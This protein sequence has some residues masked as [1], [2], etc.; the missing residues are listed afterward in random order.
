VTGLNLEEM[1]VDGVL[2][3]DVSGLGALVEGGF[4]EARMIVLAAEWHALAVC[5]HCDLGS[6][7]AVETWAVLMVVGVRVEETG[8][9]QGPG[10]EG[11]CQRCSDCKEP[12]GCPALV[13][14][15]AGSTRLADGR[16]LMQPR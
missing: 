6:F 1:V 3:G 14:G 16:Q 7:G 9:A 4:A 10:G 15:A 12:C 11:A 5:L 2:L 8:A 13:S